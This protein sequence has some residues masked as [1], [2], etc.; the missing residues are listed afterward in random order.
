VKPLAG[1]HDAGLDELFVELAHVGESFS[2]GMTPA[3]DPSL[4]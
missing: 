3:S 2:L 1:E 4:P